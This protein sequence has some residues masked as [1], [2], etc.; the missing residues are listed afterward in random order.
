MFFQSLFESNLNNKFFFQEILYYPEIA[1]TSDLVWQLNDD[2]SNFL[3]NLLVF[4]D[5]QTNGRGRGSNKWFSFPGKSI[6]CSFLIDSFLEDDQFNLHALLVPLLIV[7][8]IKKIALINVQIKW[9]NDIVYDGKKLGGVLI[10]TRGI[11]KKLNIGIGLN[12]NELKQDFPSEL[13]SK[14]TSIREIIGYPI[15]R[16]PLLAIFFN[17]LEMIIKKFERDN[18]IKDWMKHCAHIDKKVSFNYNGKRI[19]GNF[20]SVNKSGQ[21]IIN[22]NNQ[23][24]KYDGF[25]KIL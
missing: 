1:S 21:A 11:N 24:I 5:N 12:V 13:Y 19:V 2:K 9:P 15:Q 25:I 8:A 16:E 14:A 23:L 7:K 20:K 4:T 22:Y 17:E 3:N 10:E 6:T 18:I